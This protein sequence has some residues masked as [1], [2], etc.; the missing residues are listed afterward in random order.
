MLR[1]SLRLCMWLRLSVCEC[2]LCLRVRGIL[3]Q[4]HH[5]RPPIY[6]HNK[7]R[8]HSHT[9]T[10]HTITLS[11]THTPYI[12]T[13]ALSLSLSHTHKMNIVDTPVHVVHPTANFKTHTRIYTTHFP[14]LTHTL[15]QTQEI[16]IIDTPGHVDFTIEVEREYSRPQYACV[17]ACLSFQ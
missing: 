14:S 12:H 10:A 11:H 17:S 13:L 15:S 8:T 3:W 2:V 9:Y 16:N 1:I 6:R 5:S 4:F 7:Q